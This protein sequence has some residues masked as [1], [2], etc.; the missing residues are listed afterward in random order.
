[1]IFEATATL[2]RTA[3]MVDRIRVDDKRVE[4]AGRSRIEFAGKD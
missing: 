2:L 3:S 1:M 4:F